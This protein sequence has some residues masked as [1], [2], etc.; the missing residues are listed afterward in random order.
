MRRPCFAIVPRGYTSYI[1]P[2]FVSIISFEAS[3]VRAV[4]YYHPTFKNSLG[5][6]SAL[7]ASTLH[8]GKHSYTEGG[9]LSV[10]MHQIHYRLTLIDS[11]SLTEKAYCACPAD[12]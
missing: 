8:L 1:N 10:T 4:G 7:E 2:I 11:Y 5:R 6:T 3:L 9:E 12:Y